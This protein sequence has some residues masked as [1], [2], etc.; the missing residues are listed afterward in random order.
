MNTLKNKTE[1]AYE[2]LQDQMR[3]IVHTLDAKDQEVINMRFGLTD[4][5]SH[6]LDE[7]CRKFN[8]TR[9]KIRCIEAK[10]LRR[11]RKFQTKKEKKIDGGGFSGNKKPLTKRQRMV[12]QILSS[13]ANKD[14]AIAAD[15]YGLNENP[16]LSTEETCKLFSI[17]ADELRILEGKV[18]RRID[19]SP[20]Q[21]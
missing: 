7:L 11:V 20:L 1:T 6:T 21:N 9:E 16:P 18:Q 13:L 14:R 5:N 12:K 15:R 3:Q 19:H 8:L 2:L 17:T 10:A 4:G